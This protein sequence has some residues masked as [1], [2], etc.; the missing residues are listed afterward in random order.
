MT[1]AKQRT[2]FQTQT[3]KAGEIDVSH[4]DYVLT[5]GPGQRQATAYTPDLCTA[6][7]DIG[8]R[9]KAEGWPLE[10]S[11]CLIGSCTT[12]PT[13]YILHPTSYIIRLIGSYTNLSV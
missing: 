8:S 1:V 12:H 3:Q 11:S 2:M 10:I 6:V 5:W 13:S 9:A 7:K 4:K